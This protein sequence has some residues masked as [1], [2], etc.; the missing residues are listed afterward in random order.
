M[1]R[2]GAIRTAL[3]VGVEVISPFMEW[4]NRNVAVLFGDGAG[5]VVVSPTEEDR[6][7]RNWT[8]GADG[9][10]IEA[11]GGMEVFIKKGDRVLLKVNA[12]FVTLG[13]A[14]MLVHDRAWARLIEFPQ[15]PPGPGASPGRRVTGQ[16]PEEAARRPARARSPRRA[17]CAG[18]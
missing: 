8:L 14:I 5:A 15:I 6:G 1:I 17:G 16:M 3:V 10:G 4:S 18:P 11:L 9:R 13:I 12:A 7:V 2:T